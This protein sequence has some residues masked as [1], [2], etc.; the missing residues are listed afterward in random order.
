MKKQSK[1]LVWKLLVIIVFVG[2]S[3][4]MTLAKM[5]TVTGTVTD[6]QGNPLVGI[7]V[8]VKG[9]NMGTVTDYDGKFTMKV[10]EGKTIVFA[11]I[12]YVKQ[13]YNVTKSENIQI[14]LKED[15][16]QLDELVVVSYGVQKKQELTGNVSAVSSDK[17]SK[18]RRPEASVQ[19]TAP[20]IVENKVSESKDMKSLGQLQRPVAVASPKPIGSEKYNSYTENKFINPK[21]EALSTFSIDVD[22]ES[23]TNFRRFVNQGQIPT[24]D[25]IR[26]EEF[27]NF[28]KYKYDEPTDGNSVKVTT[29]V[30]ECPWDKQNR[31]LR[32]SVKAKDMEKAKL[33]ASNLVFLID[34]SGS[35]YGSNRLDLVKSSMKMLVNTLRPQDRVAIVVYASEVGQKLASTP[36][37][38]KAVINGV[39]DQLHASGSTNGAGGL[40]KAYEIAQ[41]NFVKGGNN[42]IILCSDGDFNVGMTSTDALTKLVEEE[43][44]SGVFLSVLG[45]G[46][47]NYKSSIMQTLAEKGN[48]NAFYIDNIQEANRVLVKEFGGS[49]FNIAKDVKLQLEFNPA[50]VQAYR[51]VGYESRLLAKE[52]F[53]DDTKDAGEMGMGQTVTALYE[54]IPAG[55]NSNKYP[56]VDDLKYQKTAKEWSQSNLVDS[57]EL[58]T[59]KLRYKNT[60]SDKSI[61][62]EQAVL[63][64]KKNAVSSDMR[65]ASAVAMFCQL[66]KGSD[67][68][69]DASYAQVIK[70]AKSGIGEDTDGYKAE[71]I[72]LVESVS[73]M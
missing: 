12:G 8:F 46:M 52:D 23:Y 61:K 11:Y 16:T 27:I 30:G 35:M 51:L 7:S 41:Q 45:Y 17:V 60:E 53:N 47:G 69:G 28:F 67:Y 36:G 50:Q 6:K 13:E 21:D 31:L 56:K 24:K 43:R 9:T 14:T 40:Q 39:I 72:R 20:V 33:P 2:V 57:P 29:E 26:I 63:D 34:V 54:I 71:F 3:V 37:N 42:R 15:V 62:L 44:K 64:N 5:V 22:T 58:L 73:A 10:E 38:Q 18:P 4:A 59:V 32:V 66:L 48:G 55:V 70:L 19:Y 49:L 68:K 1:K 65:F 25:A